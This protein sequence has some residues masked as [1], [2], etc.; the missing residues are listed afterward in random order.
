LLSKSDSK[1]KAIGT[2]VIT[3]FAGI[4]VAKLPNQDYKEIIETMNKIADSKKFH[5]A[6]TIFIKDLI[7]IDKNSDPYEDK[8]AEVTLCFMK[9]LFSAIKESVPKASQAKAIEQFNEALLTQMNNDNSVVL[10][11]FNPI[12][13]S[14]SPA[15]KNNEQSNEARQNLQK[16]FELGL[17]KYFGE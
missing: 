16:G 9:V 13:Q 4:I 6:T 15:Q 1:N 8:V 17:K 14:I 10:A 11:M 5:V 2:E 12:M 3:A 7:E